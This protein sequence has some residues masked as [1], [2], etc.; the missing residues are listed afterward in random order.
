MKKI[1]LSDYL[2]AI[3]DKGMLLPDYI[4]LDRIRPSHDSSLPELEEHELLKLISKRDKHESLSEDEEHGRYRKAS[5]SKD[6]MAIDIYECYFVDNYEVQVLYFDP[7]S[8]LNSLDE[9][10]YIKSMIFFL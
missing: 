4:K 6:T 9:L 1:L 2:E 5:Y 7:E 8:R 10:L 3:L